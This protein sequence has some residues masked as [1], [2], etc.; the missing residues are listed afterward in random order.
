MLGSPL[1][2]DSGIFYLF[3]YKGSVAFGFLPYDHSI[4]HY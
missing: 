4:V 2:F 1:T 3:T